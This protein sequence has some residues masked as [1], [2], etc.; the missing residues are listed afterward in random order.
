[1]SNASDDAA[2]G[3]GGGGPTEPA[4]AVFT[5]EV[6]RGREAEFEEW[7]RQVTETIST[8]PGSLGSTILRPKEPGGVYHIVVQFDDSLRLAD[9]LESNERRRWLGAIQEIATR[10][11]AEATGMET[12]FS[13]PKTT[14]IPPPRWKMVIV[15]FIA[16]YP[17]SLVLN[18]VAIPR[19][20][21]FPTGLRA[22]LFP[23]VLPP[24][25]TY[26]LMPLLSR[27]LR[28]WL[29]SASAP[30]PIRHQ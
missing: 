20:S 6:K 18:A 28:R 3:S 1:V 21:D 23:L 4:T 29:Y 5:W 26:V 19:M 11:G 2:G 24:V 15:T 12:W 10:E 17:L 30:T 25:L 7:L 8:Q 16:V 14:V 27:V 13:L 22:L 9:W